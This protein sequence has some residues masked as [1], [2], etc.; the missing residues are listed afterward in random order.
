MTNTTEKLNKVLPHQIFKEVRDELIDFIE[1]AE[2]GEVAFL[3]G[4]HKVG[5]KTVLESALCKT[6]DAYTD[7][8]EKNPQLMPV[9]AYELETS[10]DDK[11]Y[12]VDVIESL[13]QKLLP[14]FD[15]P[16]VER[17]VL[18]YEKVGARLKPSG[19][20]EQLTHLLK[21]RC[22]RVIALYEAH[23]LSKKP[24]LLQLVLDTFRSIAKKTG[25]VFIIV[26]D[27]HAR[28]LSEASNGFL[29][30]TTPI[31]FPVYNPNIHDEHITG[32]SNIMGA[33]INILPG[34][35]G[36]DLTKMDAEVLSKSLGNYGLLVEWMKRAV[37][38]KL[39]SKT[40][41]LAFSECLVKTMKS[42]YQ[43]IG[44]QD[45]IYGYESEEEIKKLKKELKEK[46]GAV[47][48]V[49]PISKGNRRPGK[50]TSGKRI[51]VE[52]D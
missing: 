29:L 18:A 41:D 30:S 13:T 48:E 24:A 31:H 50:N 8:R 46:Q 37:R 16:E 49:K 44:V 28:E 19:K 1:N 23:V 9:L 21:E 12:V 35:D 10:L 33:L 40:H 38:T 11:T 52:E 22:T 4:A 7:Y 17:A 47:K 15:I 3:F 14:Q 32:W 20:R 45:D 43:L 39:R 51:V 42:E 6:Q 34:K 25:S 2:A 5:K 27:Y 36:R 26:G